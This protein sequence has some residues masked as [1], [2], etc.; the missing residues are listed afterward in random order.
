MTEKTETEAN[1]GVFRAGGGEDESCIKANKQGLELF[2]LEL[3]KASL[4]SEINKPGHEKN[5]YHLKINEPWIAEDSDVFL[6]HIEIQSGAR[7]SKIKENYKPSFIDNL[8]PYGCG[9]VLIFLIVALII[10]L[11]TIIEFIL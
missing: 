11:V 8:M 10:G 2:A 3:L 6:Y 9:L 1:F 7:I 5:I 4:Q